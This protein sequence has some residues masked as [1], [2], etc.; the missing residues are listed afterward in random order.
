MSLQRQT[1]DHERDLLGRRI[2]PTPYLDLLPGVSRSIYAMYRTFV[3]NRHRIW[4]ARQ[5]GEPQPWAPTDPILSSRKF[6]NVFRV[7]DPG[8]QYVVGM[9][10]EPGLEPRDALARAALYRFTNRPETWDHVK[11]V[12]G[13]WP[14][15]DDMNADLVKILHETPGGRSSAGPTSSCRHP[16]RRATRCWGPCGWHVL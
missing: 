8:S 6:T 12:L 15:A 3:F 11:A 2:I 14:L 9:L 16:A 5:A 4:E 10:Q 13:R 1:V 7:L